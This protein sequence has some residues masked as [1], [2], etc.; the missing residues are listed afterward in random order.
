MTCFSTHWFCSSST[1]LLSS[2]GPR[3]LVSMFKDGCF[4]NSGELKKENTDQ[5]A[6]HFLLNKIVSCIIVIN[7]VKLFLTVQL[8]IAGYTIFNCL[9]YPI[10][11]RITKASSLELPVTDNYPTRIT[12]RTWWAFIRAC[13]F[14]RFKMA[15]QQPNFHSKSRITLSKIY[16]ALCHWARHYFFCLVLVQPSETHPYMTE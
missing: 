7:D 9:C 4:I 10:R 16:I 11:R 13:T 12:K 15:C 6:T 1:I 5:D 3:S 8:Y 14:V 2:S